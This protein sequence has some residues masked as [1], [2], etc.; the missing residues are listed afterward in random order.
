M[1]KRRRWF[2]TCIVAGLV[3]SV[4]LGLWPAR[5]GSHNPCE[6]P[7]NLTVNCGFDTFAD[8]TFA[9]KRIQVPQGWWHF[10]VSGDLDFRPSND[11]YWGAPSLWLLSDGVP[12]CAGVYQQVQVTPGVVYLADAGWAAVTKTDFE[13]KIGLDP[14]GGTDPQAASVIWGPSEWG[15]NSWPDLTASARA[16][17]PTMTVFVWANHPVTYGNDWIFFDAVGLWPDPDQPAATL[18][19]T[20]P[21]PTATRPRPTRTATQ[22]PPTS[23]NTATAEPPTVTASST[24]SA[25]PTE[26]PTVTE[27]PNAVDTPT[28]AAPTE[29]PL[30]SRTP[31]PT[32][33]PVARAIARADMSGG[34]G[35][36][37]GGVLA[38]PAAASGG[39]SPYLYIAAGAL[40]LGGLL[41]GVVVWLC[42]RNRMLVDEGDR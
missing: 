9:G 31:L 5:A 18:T 30:P 36:A 3:L 11:T 37:Q 13:R 22:V 27:T 17:G 15:L 39:A 26:I 21:P 25:T 40:G 34:G 29:T 14:T 20:P 28:A 19:P 4:A 33:V 38:G 32:V 1:G 24:P 8:Q 41:V 2:V 23:T 6:K 35:Q 7:G 12:F 42:R 16:V 10:V